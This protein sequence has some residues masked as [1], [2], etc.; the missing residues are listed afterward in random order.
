M[1]T[2]RQNILFVLSKNLMNFK[3]FLLIKIKF[4]PKHY[5]GISGKIYIKVAGAILKYLNFCCYPTEK[6]SK[7]RHQ[8]TRHG[9]KTFITQNK[10][11]SVLYFNL[12]R[13][14]YLYL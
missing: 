5:Y 10:S 2:V 13:L 8:L 7:K 1:V 6:D 14:V 9:K 3:W 11:V 12:T 4:L